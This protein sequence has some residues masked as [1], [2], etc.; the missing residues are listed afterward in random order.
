MTTVAPVSFSLGGRRNVMVGFD[1]LPRRT[2]GF[3]PTRLSV[4]FVMSLSSPIG[5]FSPGAPFGHRSMTTCSAPNAVAAI[6][7]RSTMDR[8]RLKESNRRELV[9]G[10]SLNFGRGR[11]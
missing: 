4:G 7:I 1:T 8:M 9:E 5:S 10:I 2:T 11:A 6:R 3:P